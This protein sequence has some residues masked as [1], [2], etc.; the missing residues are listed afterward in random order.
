[1][2]LDQILVSTAMPRMIVALQ[3]YD[4]SSWGSIA[5]L[6]TSTVTVE[7]LGDFT[8]LSGCQLH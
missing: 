1:M 7:C 8:D 2:V 3:G 6:L 5:Y 4:R